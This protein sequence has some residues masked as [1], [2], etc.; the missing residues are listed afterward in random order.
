M[1]IRDW[2]YVEDHATAIWLV[3]QEGRVGETYNIGGL[4]EQPNI[5]IVKKD[6]RTAGPEVAS[7][8]PSE[9]RQPD[10]ACHRPAGPRPALCHQLHQAA[11]R[12]WLGTPG[13]FRHRHRKDGGLVFAE[14]RPGPLTS[15]RGNMRASASAPRSD[16]ESQRHHP[17]RRLRHPALSA[18]DCRLE[19]THAGSTTNRWSIIHCRC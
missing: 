3:L 13:E 12:T 2:L 11:E 18:D 4:N 19:A 17:R 15:R 5:A 14:P 9:L 6:L 10:H 16:H 1:Q 7:R 8:R